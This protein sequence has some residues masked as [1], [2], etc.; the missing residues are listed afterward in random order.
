MQLDHAYATPNVISLE[1]REFRVS[2]SMD[3]VPITVFLQASLPE[4]TFGAFGAGEGVPPSI[5]F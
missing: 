5:P 2:N 4:C 1:S 3:G